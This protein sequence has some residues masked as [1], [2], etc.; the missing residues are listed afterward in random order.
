MRKFMEKYK[1]K[2]RN[3]ILL[4]PVHIEMTEDWKHWV[5]AWVSRFPD[6]NDEFSLLHLDSLC[7]SKLDYKSD[8]I[9]NILKFTW[10]WSRTNLVEPKCPQQKND[11]DWGLFVLQ[12][13]H[14]IVAAD[15]PENVIIQGIKSRNMNNSLSKIKLTRDILYNIAKKSLKAEKNPNMSIINEKQDDAGSS[16]IEIANSDTEIKHFLHQ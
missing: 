4:I 10:D 3:P 12:Y 1:Q 13:M 9:Y 5:L 8:D 7:G 16:V 15:D 2:I 6:I 14:N 11:I